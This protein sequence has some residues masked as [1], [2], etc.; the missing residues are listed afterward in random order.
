MSTTPTVDEL[1]AK[2]FA[3]GRDPRSAE[4]KAGVRAMLEKRLNGQPL[5]MPY[6]QGTAQ[7]DA[8]FASWDEGSAIYRALKEND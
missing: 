3:P 8:Y 1:I 6:A 7:C 4:Y 5:P 2:A